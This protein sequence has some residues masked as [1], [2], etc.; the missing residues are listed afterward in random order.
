[1]RVWSTMH[2]HGVFAGA[3]MAS[4][5]LLLNNIRPIGILASGIGYLSFLL[6][7]SR[8]VWLG[9]VIALSSMIINLKPQLK[10]KLITFLG[11]ILI[12]VIPLIQIEPFSTQIHARLAT[13]SDISND[14]SMVARQGIYEESLEKSLTNFVGDGLNKSNGF[15]SGIITMFLSLGWPGTILY[16]VAILT[17]CFKL[18]TSPFISHDSFASTSRAIFYG[19]CCQMLG[20]ATMLGLPGTIMWGFAGIAFAA[21]RYY[22][23]LYR[24]KHIQS[25]ESVNSE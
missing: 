19:T 13:F 6:T 24:T 20:G 5:L 10:I 21:N 2:S 18:E 23:E 1:M 14:G 4:L 8:T 17:V 16:M 11:V 3:M 7:A 15:D 12:A 9:W 25:M 22:L